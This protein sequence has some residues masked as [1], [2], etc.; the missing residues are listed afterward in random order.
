MYNAEIAVKIYFRGRMEYLS[1]FFFLRALLYMNTLRVHL[2]LKSYRNDCPY[3]PSDNSTSMTEII[4]Q[5]S[6][7]L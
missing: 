4:Y 1:F 6:P 3:K 2:R 5:N 7:A